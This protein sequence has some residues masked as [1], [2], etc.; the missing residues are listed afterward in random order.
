M[1][2]YDIIYYMYIIYYVCVCVCV[3]VCMYIYIMYI[4]DPSQ[5]CCV[6]KHVEMPFRHADVTTGCVNIEVTRCQWFVQT[7][8]TL[9]QVPFKGLGIRV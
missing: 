6:C 8:D 2:I 3:C 1:Y 5:A 4:Q 7:E 9:I